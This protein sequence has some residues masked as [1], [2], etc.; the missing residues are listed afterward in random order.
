[1]TVSTKMKRK[2]RVAKLWE[3]PRNFIPTTSANEIYF[4]MV[5]AHDPG[6]HGKISAN[7]VSRIALSLIA[8]PTII[9]FE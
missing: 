1:M 4:G 2:I 6:V 3:D 8:C 7:L 9:G 5:P